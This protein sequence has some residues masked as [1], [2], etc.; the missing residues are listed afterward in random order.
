[1]SKRVKR[2][3]RLKRVK[4]LKNNIKKIKIYLKIFHDIDSFHLSF[5]I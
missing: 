3:K 5:K 1:M 4:R 2:A